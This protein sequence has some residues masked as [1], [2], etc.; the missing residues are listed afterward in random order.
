M[1]LW[2]WRITRSPSPGEAL[3][4]RVGPIAA[5]ANLEPGARDDLLF[6][7]KEPGLQYRHIICERA[8]AEGSSGIR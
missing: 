3:S 2:P 1:D 8:L 7:R 6:G 5:Q 4:I